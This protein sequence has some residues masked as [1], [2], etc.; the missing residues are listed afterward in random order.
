M[1]TRTR[2][3]DPVASGAEWATVDAMALDTP[4]AGDLVEYHVQTDGPIDVR[5]VSRMKID[6]GTGKRI[7]WS[8]WFQTFWARSLAALDEDTAGTFT[9]VGPAIGEESRL[10]VRT[11][12]GGEG[13]ANWQAWGRAYQSPPLPVVQFLFGNA[14]QPAEYPRLVF[15]VDSFADVFSDP[16]TR[17][18]QLLRVTL[19]AGT[20]AAF[21][22]A[23]VQF[24]DGGPW[25]L[26]YVTTSDFAELP[27][28]GQWSNETQYG[29]STAI[30][31]VAINPSTFEAW[32]WTGAEWAAGDG[33][34]ATFTVASFADLPT[35]STDGQTVLV[36]NNGQ[37]GVSWCAWS[38]ADDRWLVVHSVVTGGEGSLPAGGEWYNAGGVLAVSAGIA[39]ATDGAGAAWRVD[40]GSWVPIGGPIGSVV[41]LIRLEGPMTHAGFSVVIGV[42]AYTAS[43]VSVSGEETAED[44]ITDLVGQI[45]AILAGVDP[46]KGILSVGTSPG[47]SGEYGLILALEDGAM[48]SATAIG[49]G[50]ALF[51]SVATN[52]P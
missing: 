37:G 1:N 44:V 51:T 3:M 21:S 23:I 40:G 36:T 10:E 9:I 5:I 26:L 18:G 24:E 38:V 49:D 7:V 45:T 16:E 4:G 15:T 34:G 48:V 11:A 29:V 17:V 13:S 52:S 43:F 20:F 39:I 42:G 12:D 2:T 14:A 22:D 25:N 28:N 46:P 6:D 8:P 19:G 33:G 50:P 27:V 41:Y 47:V 32:H 35:A 31:A 30:G